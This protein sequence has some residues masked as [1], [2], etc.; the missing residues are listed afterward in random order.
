MK[1]AVKNKSLT[2]LIKHKFREF[3]SEF[4]LPTNQQ[5]ID[6]NFRFY[7][8]NLMNDLIGYMDKSYFF[9]IRKSLLEIFHLK[10]RIP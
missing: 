7:F 1:K 6:T 2:A 5:P 3:L 9:S 8:F 4:A 10:K